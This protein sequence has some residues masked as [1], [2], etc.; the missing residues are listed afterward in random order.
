MWQRCEDPSLEGLAIATDPETPWHQVMPGAPLMQ[1]VADGEQLET[2]TKSLLR[3]DNDYVLLE[4]MRDAQ[5]YRLALEI[6]SAGTR[7][8]KATV[9]TGDPVNLPYTIAS[10]IRSKYGGDMAGIILQIF[11]NF[12][13]VLQFGSDDKDR[14]KK[15]LL[16]IWEYCYDPDTDVPSVHCICR[17]DGA[18]RWQW[19]HH[20]G[21]DKKAGAVSQADDLAEMEEIMKDLERRNPLT[22]GRVIYPRYYRPASA[23]NPQRYGL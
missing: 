23:E 18:G 2:I 8:S 9:H 15:R 12:N 6:T 21:Q 11:R 17:Y 10:K 14:S 4:E 19:H 13:Y 20:I 3:G 7:R 22:E 5:A 16:G 1:L